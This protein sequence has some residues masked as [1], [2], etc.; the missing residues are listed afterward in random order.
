MET[1]GCY[2]LRKRR[3]LVTGGAGYLGSTMVPILLQRGHHV[4]VYDKF[5]WGAFPLLPHAANPNLEI[6]RG[7]ILDRNLLARHMEDCDVIIHLA[8]IVGYPAC[9]KFHD[10]AIQVNVEGTRNIVE[11]LAEDQHLIYAST[12]SCY[13]AV[14]NGVCDEETLISPLTLYGRTKAEGEKL[15]LD[16][17]GVALRL[18]TVFGV[19]PRLRLDLLVNDLTDKALRLQHFDLYQGGFRRTF[20]HV[21]D[22][23]RAF[24]FAAENYKEM[25]GQAFNVGDENMNL[26]KSDVAC[27]IQECVPGCLITQS[28]SGE[29]KDKRD[30]EVS[31][32]KVRSLGYRATISVEEGVKE[33]VK[34]LPCLSEEEIEKARNI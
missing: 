18:A 12:G 33:L 14:Q 9:E 7:D 31:Y 29:D 23:A 11:N 15:V 2:N 8:A 34:F 22:A 24:V 6:V 27:I 16:A 10:E 5:M 26:S 25:A 1:N 17:G 13:G 19:S 3:V 21:K 28:N 30:Y 32:K 4:V 20:L